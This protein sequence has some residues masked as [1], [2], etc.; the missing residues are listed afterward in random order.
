MATD[1]KQT[2][3]PQYKYID[4]DIDRDILMTNLKH[5]AQKYVQHK[6]WDESRANE[7]YSALNNFEK[8]I[9]ENR[10]SSDQSGSILDSAGTLND[11]S[12]NWRDKEGKIISE[13]EYNN[14]SDKH[15]KNY[16]QDFFAN[17]E[18]ARYI[19]TVAKTVYN[20]KLESTKSKK[21]SSTKK[22]SY[23]ENNL[24]KSFLN[25]LAP[26][27]NGDVLA[28][29]DLDPY[30]ETKKARQTTNRAKILKEYIDKHREE[31]SKLDWS[32]YSED[33]KNRYLANLTQLQTEL[34]NGVTDT[35]Y[36]ILN[37]LG[38]DGSTYRA[39]FTKDKLYDAKSELENYTGTSSNSSSGSSSNSGNTATPV[40]PEQVK[41][42][43]ALK[44]EF[45]KKY[46]A[47]NYLTYLA[48][49]N[50]GVP[51]DTSG[52]PGEQLTSFMDNLNAK[53]VDLSPEH[54]KKTKGNDVFRYLG[55]LYKLNPSAFKTAK[56]GGFYSGWV[57][58]PESLDE[59]TMTVLGYNPSTRKTRRLSYKNISDETYA[60]FM[61]K[62]TSIDS[63]RQSQVH[64]HADGGQISEG[65]LENT[66]SSEPQEG[67]SLTEFSRRQKQ[68]KTETQNDPK[69]RRFGKS[70]GYNA[71]GF[72][73][74][75]FV[76]LGAIA[77]DIGALVDP[78]P[79]SAT[80][81]GVGSDVANLY[82]D[83]KEG[84]GVGKSLLNFGANLGLSTLGAIPIL[85]DAAGSGSK[86]IKNLV[87]F[88]PKINK[89][90]MGAIAAGAIANGP[91]I[92]R[93]LS[94]INKS[95]VENE[96]NVQDWKNIA[97]A[98]QLV[99]GVT[100]GIKSIKAQKRV[101]AA[102]STNML[103]VRVKDAV[104]G[105]VKTLRFANKEDV[106][107]LRAATTPEE[108]NA[109][110]QSHNSY[111]NAEVLTS[112]SKNLEFMGDQSKWYNP[113]SWWTRNTTSTAQVS[114]ALDF[115]AMR[116]YSKGQSKWSIDHYYRTT[117]TNPR[118]IRKR[119]TPSTNTTTQPTAQPVTPQ[120]PTVVTN[121]GIGTV[122]GGGTA[123]TGVPGSIYRKGGKFD[124]GG[125]FNIG[126]FLTDNTK[127]YPWWES[128]KKTV[129]VNIPL[130][131]PNPYANVKV[132][133]PSNANYGLGYNSNIKYTDLE[134]GTDDLVNISGIQNANS[135]KR[136]KALNPNHGDPSYDYANAQYNTNR[137]REQWQSNPDNRI[138]DMKTF[139]AQYLKE[140]PNATQEEF[141]AAYNTGID[142][143]YS[144]KNEMG[145]PS[146]Q[147]NKSYRHDDK[148]KQF[149]QTNKAYYSSANSANG[150][151]G[152]SV[153]QEGFNGTTTAQRFIDITPDIM[154]G[155]DWK[156]NE[157]DSEQLRGLLNGLIKDSTGRYY[158]EKP[159]PF[160]IEK[161]NTN[162]PKIN[163]G[164]LITGN[165][166]G[167]VH[168]STD[169][170]KTTKGSG[171]NFVD[172]FNQALPNA[173]R[174]SRY[175]NTLKHN[176]RILDLA[177]Q[178]PV[179]LYDPTEAN[180]WIIGDEQA[181]M[182]GRRAL[183]ELNDLASTPT[184]SDGANYTAAQMEANIK[185]RNYV[186]AGENQD[187]A[188]K[189]QTREQSWQQERVNQQS[190]YSTAV[191]NRDN[192]FS[193]ATNVIKARAEHEA[194][195]N[196]ALQ[197]LLG[198]Y[199][200]E[201]MLRNE[202]NK[203][204]RDNALQQSLQNR[205]ASSM[206]SYGIDA[207]Q[208]DQELL[209]SIMS[210]NV[211]YANLSKEQQTRFNQLSTK[212]KEAA[213]REF[214]KTKGIN[215][216]PYL[217]STNGQFSLDYLDTPATSSSTTSTEAT[218]T[219][220]TTT[221][222]STP[223]LNP[224]LT[225]LTANFNRFHAPTTL[226]DMYNITN[227]RKSLLKKGGKVSDE[228]V[229]IQEMRGKIKQMELFQK[230]M[231]NQIKNLQKTLDRSQKSFDGYINQQTRK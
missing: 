5:N 135:L 4:T 171:I 30:D 1:N 123:F 26:S 14:L 35:D 210:G 181:V 11:G 167:V 74:T 24:F 155:I 81:L 16:R 95:G 166:G 49:D 48:N 3:K 147:G 38:S 198:E 217:A 70:D 55:Q 127:T 116:N 178:L 165:P 231:N 125:T 66:E 226:I 60:D 218:P 169:P 32:D 69:R 25:N 112:D 103:D 128:K 136:D 53:G 93:S 84:Y 170:E 168:P 193:K 78:E 104:T 63:Y 115:N 71:G 96:M 118:V 129:E 13:I 9:E 76:R 102:G 6:G 83:L 124:I 137:A 17:K 142:S 64:K 159:S 203:T 196:A 117:K 41:R 221:T 158:T 152:Y 99:L 107:A 184:T 180:R 209:D 20:K 29:L 2:E 110:I 44:Q 122:V 200:Q 144:Y 59:T 228:A 139:A 106:K 194:A 172:I 206:S 62:L 138:N 80:A 79:I 126:E 162:I 15:K 156:F 230:S 61:N 12:S 202:E 161:P 34:D 119:P 37:Q 225:T 120:Q 92:L 192:L 150:V 91:D 113:F 97:S 8:A 100:K 208:E 33:E 197:T 114:D 220:T 174:I 212:V 130:A 148:V 133:L 214:Y 173:L 67:I 134:Y 223:V 188:M 75:D 189:A 205:I 143:M 27:G 45:V 121:P 190:R 227:P 57:Y 65:E 87:K 163:V 154:K 52:D 105:K 73:S 90:L 72:T 146:F 46:N 176:D 211:Q 182:S 23:T 82:S 201:A 31:V 101:R 109:V 58:I 199:Q 179:N 164:E 213:V 7:F 89:F 85:G 183:G 36:R 22:F 68:R 42:L 47:S 56:A 132:G 28:Y 98:L 216:E 54:L 108:I 177:K 94:K 185:G 207:T 43:N 145:S 77:T 86:I 131:A 10:L 215:I 229:I 19:N 149:N 21:D 51:Y 222:T 191:K 111:K 18:V 151:H 153:P 186:V 39:F 160:N 219:I 140:H 204:L 195:N 141:L 88:A 157:N 40:D 187:S 175:L 224:Y 50:D